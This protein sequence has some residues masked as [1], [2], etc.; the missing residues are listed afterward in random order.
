M[1]K[2]EAIIREEALDT[3]KKSLRDAGI[4]PLTVYPVRGRGRQGGIVYRWREGEEFYD[5]LPRVKLEIVVN[6]E[7]VEKVIEIITKSVRRGV[8]G[9]GKIFIIPIEEV[10]RIR[11]GQRGK[12]AVA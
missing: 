12:D 3:V 9:D 1:K 7:D 8:P 10:I 6:D 4:T 11:T 5:L 2:I